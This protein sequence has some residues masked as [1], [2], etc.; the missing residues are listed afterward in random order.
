MTRTE[1]KIS[2]YGGQGVLTLGALI[3]N[4]AIMFTETLNASQSESYGAA[5]RGGACWSEVV[6]EDSPDEINYPRTTPKNVDVG[7]FMT[8]EAVSKYLGEVRREGGVV[9]YDPS[10]V[11]KIRTKSTQLVYSIPAQQMARETLKNPLTA[12]VIM[13]GAFTAIT[14]VFD[15]EAALKGVKTVAPPKAYDI[16]VQAFNVGYDF[17]LEQKKKL[18]TSAA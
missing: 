6:V 15:K 1:V 10:S 8:D 17:A 12:N 16:N 4:T 11:G 14:E 3:T 5:A 13:F 7:I 18:K 2:G 9:I